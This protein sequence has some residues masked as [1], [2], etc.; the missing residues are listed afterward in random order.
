MSELQNMPWTLDITKLRDKI[1]CEECRHR[2]GRKRRNLPRLQFQ[3]SSHQIAAPSPKISQRNHDFIQD[4]NFMGQ[5]IFLPDMWLVNLTWKCFPHSL[6]SQILGTLFPTSHFLFDTEEDLPNHLHGL[7]A[8][9]FTN[10]QQTGCPMNFL[11]DCLYIL[12][13]GLLFGYLTDWRDGC[14][15]TCH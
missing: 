2:S 3:P 12:V 13:S 4:F 5:D 10:E 15:F 1:S 6:L 11:S 14:L 9:L 7:T 8:Q